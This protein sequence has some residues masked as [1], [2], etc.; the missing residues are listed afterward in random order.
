ML[1]ADSHVVTPIAPLFFGAATL[2][3]GARRR[4]MHRSKLDGL[5]KKGR[6]AAALSEV[7]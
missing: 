5:N 1:G 3:D 2:R 4:L 7:A 6:L